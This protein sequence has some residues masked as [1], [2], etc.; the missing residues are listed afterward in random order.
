MGTNDYPVQE[1]HLLAFGAIVQDFARFERLIEISVSNILKANHML[2][3][4]VMASLGYAAKCDVLKSLLRIELWPD[5][6]KAL[7]ISRYIED[8][9]A[10]LPLRNAIAHHIWMASTRHNAIKHISVSSRGGKVKV[11]GLLATEKDYTVVELQKVANILVAIHEDFL[12]VLIE[13][14]AVENIAGNFNDANSTS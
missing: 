13:C 4:I 1:D 12:K 10:Y 2:T 7:R 8:F 3:A 11:H 5:Q 9:N 14:G 6:E